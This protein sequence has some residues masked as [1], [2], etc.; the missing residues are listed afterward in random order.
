M[1]LTGLTGLTGFRERKTYHGGTEARRRGGIDYANGEEVALIRV[2]LRGKRTRISATVVVWRGRRG[3]PVLRVRRT[4]FGEKRE[5][6][7]WTLMD[8]NLEGECLTGLTGLG[9]SWRARL[10]REASSF[11]LQAMA[12]VMA[13][14]AL[15]C[16]GSGCLSGQTRY[17]W[18]EGE[19][20]DRRSVVSGQWSVKR[21]GERRGN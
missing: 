19:R 9:G 15:C 3:A 20:G 13:R 11:A 6:H 21:E 4:T 7:E 10:R 14:S 1:F 8:A 18:R 16:E 5:N 12:D 17:I 2:R